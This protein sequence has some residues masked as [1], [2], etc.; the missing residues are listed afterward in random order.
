MDSE[1]FLAHWITNKK[2]QPAYD[3]LLKCLKMFQRYLDGIGLQRLTQVDHATIHQFIE[4]MRQQG[5]SRLG[6][7]GL[8]ES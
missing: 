1:P 7:I 2:V 6:R 8:S 5:N 3:G 4:Q